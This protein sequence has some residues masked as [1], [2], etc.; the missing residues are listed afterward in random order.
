MI[1]GSGADDKA[2]KADEKAEEDSVGVAEVCAG[3]RLVAIASAVSVWK[4]N[5]IL[6]NFIFES[7]AI[8]ILFSS[9]RIEKPRVRAKYVPIYPLYEP[10]TGGEV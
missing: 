8:I 10:W 2:E 9:F 3:G 7:L 6:R 5:W 1:A 4:R